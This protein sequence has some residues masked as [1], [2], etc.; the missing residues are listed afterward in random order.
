M[1]VRNADEASQAS[2]FGLKPASDRVVLVLDRSGSMGHPFPRDPIPE[3]REEWSRFREALSQLEIYLE[4]L[5]PEALF[6][7]VVFE[8]RARIW[9]SRMQPATRAHLREVRSWVLKHPPGGGTNLR[10]ALFKALVMDAK[11][12]PTEA[13][14]EVDTLV[15]LCD[16]K[17]EEGP[18]WTR[19]FL[20]QLGPTYRWIIHGVQ[21]G[22]EGDGSLEQLTQG[23]GGDFVR[24]GQ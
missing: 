8:E 10:N 20:E 18:D 14:R 3:G 1:V 23:T 16:G 21:I 12:H 22:Q 24:V 17:T 11:G 15:V 19:R 5:G 2:F 4:G 7:V 13:S 6:N 9:K